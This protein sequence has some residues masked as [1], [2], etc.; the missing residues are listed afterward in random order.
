MELVQA[1]CD[2]STTNHTTHG[3]HSV[4][5]ILLA[6]QVHIHVARDTIHSV[7]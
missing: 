6:T 7:V 5:M 2:E 4:L 3:S 1:T